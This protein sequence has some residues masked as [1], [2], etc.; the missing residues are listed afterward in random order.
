MGSI[1]KH[2]WTIVLLVGATIPLVALMIYANLAQ[3]RTADKLAV[4]DRCVDWSHESHEAQVADGPDIE[5]SC[6]LYFR[7]RSNENAGEDIQRW[8]RRA[9]RQAPNDA[10]TT[11]RP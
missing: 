6:S 9:A 10:G 11:N 5:S 2:F 4:A 8:E 3:M 1:R 7:A